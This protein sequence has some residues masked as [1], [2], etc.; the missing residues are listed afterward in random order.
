MGRLTRRRD[1]PNGFPA[2]RSQMKLTLHRRG[3]NGPPRRLRRRLANPKPGC[4]D[5]PPRPAGAA[6]FSAPAW[7]AIGRSLDLSSRE[8]QIVRGLLDGRKESAIAAG[9][10]ISLRTVHTHFERLYQKLGVANHVE[11]TLR[12]MAEFLALTASPTGG[13]PAICPHQAA[14]RC[15][16]R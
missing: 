15:P 9:L 5:S 7:K 11:L 6:V 12:L 10:G 16:L 14:G 3:R 4:V 8:S 1:P 13:L 2:L